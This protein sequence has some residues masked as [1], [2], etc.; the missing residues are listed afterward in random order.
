MAGF[1]SW[2]RQVIPWGK[3]LVGGGL[4]GG[5][6]KKPP[7][8]PPMPPPAPM[9]P[10]SNLPQYDFLQSGTWLHVASSN[11]EALR[12]LWDQET[13]EVQCKGHDP[14]GEGYYYIYYQITPTEANDF[15][16]TSSP[17][18]WVWDNL[19]IR[20][21]VTGHQKPYVRVLGFSGV[22]RV[23]YQGAASCRRVYSRVNHWRAA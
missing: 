15:V 13:L 23:R 7:V 16:M 18:R 10:G 19:R 17:G 14:N 21:T 22:S 1:F 9:P 6:G 8:V 4:F 2:L 3:S 20:G 12:Y 5:G 11:V